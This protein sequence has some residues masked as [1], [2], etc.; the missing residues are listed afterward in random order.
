MAP[1]RPRLQINASTELINQAKAIAYS[2]GL[3]LTEYILQA[4]AKDGDEKLKQLVKKE[5][6]DRTRPGNP[7]KPQS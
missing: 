6:G 7:T 3:S 2:R 4:M 1:I 5:L